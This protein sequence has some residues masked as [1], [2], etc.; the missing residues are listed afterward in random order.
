ML[1]RES[2]TK[3]AYDLT[4]RRVQVISSFIEFISKNS[5]VE[6]KNIPRSD[7]K[8]N[9]EYWF[10]QASSLVWEP[11]VASY[12]LIRCIHLLFNYLNIT[13]F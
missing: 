13:K 11:N 2:H 5:S 6:Q 9:E 12:I 3:N 4:V 7:T 1:Y 10:F 8:K